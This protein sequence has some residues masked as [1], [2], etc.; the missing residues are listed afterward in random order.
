MRKIKSYIAISLNGKIAK[1]DGGVQWLESIPNP[2]KIDYGYSEFL[3]SIDTTIQGHKTYEQ[4]LSW[5]IEFP[6]S[7]KDNYVLT[8]DPSLLDD[9]NV[10]FIK[11][12]HLQFIRELKEKEGKGIWQIG[13]GQVNTLLLNEN[14]LDELILFIMPII[15]PGGIELFEFIPKE[16]ILE[17]K[18]VKKYPTGVVE[19]KY[20]LNI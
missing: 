17:L 10:K 4:L 16:K 1:S 19:L 9:Q 3:K 12:N 7:E 15:I 8:R 5:G 14:L 11:N 2:E 13:G 18:G 6:Y 20:E